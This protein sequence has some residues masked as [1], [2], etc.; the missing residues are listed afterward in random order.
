MAVSRLRRPA[1]LVTIAV[2]A[3]CQSSYDPLDEFEQL[4]PTTIMDAPAP[5]ELSETARR[6]RYVVELLGCESCHTDGAVTGNPREDLKLAGSRTGIAYSN[7]LTEKNPGVLYPTNLTPDP[8]TGLGSWTDE[9]V[10][11][12]IAGV[13]HGL[14]RAPVM[15]RPAYAKMTDDDVQ[16]VVAYLRS[17]PAVRHRVPAHVRPGQR[18]TSPYVHFGIYR[19]KQ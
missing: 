10:A 3:G 2:L 15:P 11:A 8:E 4:E 7:P 19:S 12:A 14:R 6:G 5:T 16:A 18:A 13:T 9:Q 17:I 1:A